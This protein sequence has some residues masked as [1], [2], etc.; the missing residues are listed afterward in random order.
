MRMFISADTAEP[1]TENYLNIQTI[2]WVHISVFAHIGMLYGL[3]IHAVLMCTTP[4]QSPKDKVDEREQIYR[5]PFVRSSNKILII[6]KYS[7]KNYK[8]NEKMW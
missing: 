8:K 5:M 7:F 4:H 3:K 2:E 6:L 1:H